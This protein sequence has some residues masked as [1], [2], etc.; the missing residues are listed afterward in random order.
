MKLWLGV[1]FGIVAAAAGV[2]RADQP[3]ADQKFDEGQKLRD[4]GKLA[5]SCVLFRESLR[6][7]P[8]AIGTLLN[9]ARC[10]EEAGKLASAIR[11]YTEARDRAAEQS[12][13]RPHDAAD[14]RLR[15][16]VGRVPH[17]A[18]V[19]AAPLPPGAS[20]TA[21]DVAVATDA[22]SLADVAVDPGSVRVVV[23]A[24]G[25]VAFE[26]HVLVDEKDH[27]T[28]TIPE[29]ALP[30]SVTLRKS[31]R[32]LVGKIVTFVGAG[33]VVLGEGMALG[34]YVSW[35]DKVHSS[36]CSYYA[37][38]NDYVCDSSALSS[39]NSDRALGN[40]ATGIVIGGLVT[41]AV[42]GAIWFFSPTYVERHDVAVTPLFAPG[43]TGVTGIAASGTF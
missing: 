32:R 13:A 7:N 30:V 5:E 4:A 25:R 34:A 33:G 40:A 38:G 37:K 17:L 3:L 24:P 35:R 28:V 20:I 21:D 2:A 15:A 39:I 9:V 29:L 1:A 10:D 42:G 26:T 22:A 36:A 6:L 23:S 31:P 14:E 19:L 41:A 43:A 8:H 11:G 27:K 12:L 18:L 16:L